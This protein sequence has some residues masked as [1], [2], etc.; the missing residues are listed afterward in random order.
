[1]RTH[2]S[3]IKNRSLRRHVAV[4]RC[5]ELE[6][7]RV[8]SCTVATSTPIGIPSLTSGELTIPNAG[9]CFS[10][11]ASSG[12]TYDFSA[13]SQAVDTTLT[14]FDS[15]GSSI[16]GFD[17]D[18]G[19]GLDSRIQWEAFT[20]GTHYLK[21]EA[22]GGSV[23][24]FSLS[25]TLLDD[26]GDAASTA[27][28]MVPD[29]SGGAFNTVMGILDYTDD[30]DFFSFSATEGAFFQ[31]FVSGGRLV[32]LFDTDGETL[33]G[34][35]DEYEPIYWTAPASGTYYVRPY[36]NGFTGLGS[37]SVSILYA[38][39]HGNASSS[40]TSFAG[41]ASG[42]I[43]ANGD[44]DVF[45][46][47]AVA[48]E[49]Y[50]AT[51][52]LESL[53]DSYL[54]LFDQSG[55]NLIAQDNDG[56]AGL[57][58]S[59]WWTATT[60]GIHYLEVSG[61]GGSMGSYDL[62]VVSSWPCDFVGVPGCDENDINA[63][64]EGSNNAPTPLTDMLIDQWLIDASNVWNPLK[65]DTGVTFVQGD[66]NLDGQVDSSDL[67][68]LL[69][70]FGDGSGMNWG[71]G[72]LNSDQ[73]IDSNDLGLLLNNFDFASTTTATTSLALSFSASEDAT[74]VAALEFALVFEEESAEVPPMDL[75][76]GRTSLRNVD[77]RTESFA[78]ISHQRAEVL[79]DLALED[80]LL[81]RHLPLFS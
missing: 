29:P 34:S 37:Y 76:N 61:F 14:L 26:H 1:M 81:S 54:R 64:Y 15:G 66:V 50:A 65:V 21:V 44:V 8:L 13:A 62:S 53:G 74:E 38:D 16:L 52:M 63:L 39:D 24:P 55:T 17:D 11:N 72:N 25:A 27:T 35:T 59:I 4:L 58:S 40:S 67:G 70:N 30:R 48:G 51:T 9:S 5:E 31:V 71:Q 10:F 69:N 12:F 75:P 57:A 47:N 18:S 49:R 7:R 73:F 45:E 33:L 79:S 68:L 3:R 60:G 78:A 6:M 56:G 41:D 46:F 32:S 43:E 28:A 19:S 80:F 22:F 42:V 77:T 2:Y 36:D 23:G 20:S